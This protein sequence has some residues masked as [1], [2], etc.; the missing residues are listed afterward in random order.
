RSGVAGWGGA[1]S[2]PEHV[3]VDHELAVV[4][5]DGTR[6]GPEPGER[7]VGAG[8]PLPHRAAELRVGPVGAGSGVRS[9]CQSVG[10]GAPAAA[11]VACGPARV[12]TWARSGSLWPTQYGGA[13]QACWVTAAQ[14]SLNH[15]G[16][17]R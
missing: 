2:A 13:R 6:G 8:G 14:P 12:H 15:S 16:G 7:E 11:G 9:G 17:R 5:A 10:V 1:R 3:L 4:L